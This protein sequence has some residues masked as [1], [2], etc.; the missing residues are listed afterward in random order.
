MT[1]IN[2]KLLTTST[3]VIDG[4][5]GNYALKTV[6]HTIDPRIKR[7]IN[8]VQTFKTIDD[9]AEE[10]ASQLAKTIMGYYCEGHVFNITIKD[11]Q[12]TP[13]Q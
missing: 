12:K 3:T 6:S 5:P 8:R 7:T 11:Y 4:V 1:K 2:V 10:L 13:E 9:L